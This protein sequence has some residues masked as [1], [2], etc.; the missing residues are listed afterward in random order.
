MSFREA[1]TAPFSRSV[2]KRRNS[3][4]T[5]ALLGFVPNPETYLVWD[6]MTGSFSA[7]NLDGRMVESGRSQALGTDKLPAFLGFSLSQAF[8]CRNR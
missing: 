4:A 1:Q 6:A 5:R 3:P 7:G 8:W 2:I